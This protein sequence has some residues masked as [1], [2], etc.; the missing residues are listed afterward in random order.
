MKISVFTLLLLI[1]VIFLS[2]Q[3]LPFPTPLKKQFVPDAL[4]PAESVLI[5]GLPWEKTRS[6]LAKQ[7]SC[8]GGGSFGY[9]VPEPHGNQLLAE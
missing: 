6:F 3:D 7:D 4:Q 9:A 8:T 5:F 2:S 1:P